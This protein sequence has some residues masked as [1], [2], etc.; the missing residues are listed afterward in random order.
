MAEDRHG[1]LGQVLE[2]QHV[3]LAVASGANKARI[4]VVAPKAGRRCRRESMPNSAAAAGWG[5]HCSQPRSDG[6]IDHCR[7]LARNQR[8]RNLRLRIYLLAL[9]HS[10]HDLSAA[11]AAASSLWR[12]VRSSLNMVLI[13]ARWQR[14]P[15]LPLAPLAVLSP[16][17]RLAAAQNG[18]GK[19]WRKM[20]GAR[21]LESAFGWVAAVVHREM[22]DPIPPSSAGTFNSA[23][24]RPRIFSARCRSGLVWLSG[25]MR[26][27]RQPDVNLASEMSFRSRVVVRNNASGA[28]GASARGESSQRDVILVSCSCPG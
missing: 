7:M 27:V 6:R 2:R 28:S 16:G 18:Q 8:S 22:G 4:E 23:S 26:Q 9:A 17:P 5:Y 21:Q 25:I 15:R 10:A 11:N 24:L 12:L 13:V 20:V 3:D 14:P 19:K 1:E